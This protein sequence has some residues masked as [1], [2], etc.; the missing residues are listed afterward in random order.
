MFLAKLRHGVVGDAR[1]R[2]ALA[3]R[4]E[5]LDRRIRQ[6]NHL[7]VIAELV[8]FLEARIEIMDLAHAAQPRRDIAELRRDLVHLLREAV[9]VD[10]AIKI[11]ER[12]GAHV[13]TRTGLP[14]R[15]P[16]MSSTTPAK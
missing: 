4:G 11:D 15:K 6:R 10:V 3:G 12:V 1:Q 7:A 14:S 5:I 8:H 2:E 9:R 16:R 13:I